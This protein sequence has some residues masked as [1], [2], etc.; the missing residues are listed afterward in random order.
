LAQ[1]IS[2]F[3]PIFFIESENPFQNN[4]ND[5]GEVFILFRADFDRLG[6]SRM[7][8][9][10]SDGFDSIGISA[11]AITSS[12]INLNITVAFMIGILEARFA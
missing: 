6:L 4:A 7:V 1:E 12:R 8:N 11:I 10:E 2:G 5:L 9:T 3:E